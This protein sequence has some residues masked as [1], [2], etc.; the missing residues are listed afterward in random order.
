M[1]LWRVDDVM[2]RDVVTVD[3]Q[4][5]YQA[6]VDLVI[7]HRVSALPVVNHIGQ[8][9]GIVSE[10]DLL[11]KIEAF[12]DRR[13]VFQGSSRRRDRAKAHGRTARDVMNADVLSILPSMAVPVAAER[14][15]AAGVRRLPVEDE[16][17]RLVGIVTRS[18]LLKVRQAEPATA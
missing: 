6:L 13:W 7:A 4:T 5:P 17:G 18:D 10:T 12:D 11:H 3:E 16:L 1:R 8:V 14:M 2:T 9:V 15:L